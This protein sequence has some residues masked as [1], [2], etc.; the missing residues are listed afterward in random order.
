MTRS[1]AIPRRAALVLAG[2]A[3]ALLG[4]CVVAPPYDPGAPVYPAAT[5]P[6]QP[7][8][9][10]YGA[11]YYAPTYPAYTP[12]LSLGIYAHDGYDRRH[13]DRPPPRRPD[14]NR[15]GFNR[16]G[17]ARPPAVRP[18]RP[19][20]PSSTGPSDPPRLGPSGGGVPREELR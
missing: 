1:V 8:Y 16:P 7:Y 15:P 5:Y 18:P 13:W 3:L 10:Y 11:P 9:D 2:G 6:A 12:S 17:N 19:Q 4:G 14:Y 20:R